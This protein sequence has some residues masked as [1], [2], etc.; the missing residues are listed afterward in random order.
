MQVVS[1][2]LATT[3]YI[4][5][6]MINY[7]CSSLVIMILFCNGNQCCSNAIKDASR[8]LEKYLFCITL[9]FSVVVTVVREDIT[10]Q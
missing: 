2:T 4:Q 8:K 10:S 6:V 1:P 7:P 5:S 9:A 3:G